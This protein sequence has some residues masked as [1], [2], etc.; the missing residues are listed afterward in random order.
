MH[1]DMVELQVSN[2]NNTWRKVYTSNKDPLYYVPQLKRLKD[3]YPN[4]RVR[5]VTSDGKLLDMIP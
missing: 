5:A 4:L 1:K 3:Q 2:P